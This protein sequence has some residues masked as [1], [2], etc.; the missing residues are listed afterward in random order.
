MNEKENQVEKR[1]EGM[2]ETERQTDRQHKVEQYRIR[3]Q[4]EG[5]TD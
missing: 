5:R 1:K 3:Q 2:T 4:K